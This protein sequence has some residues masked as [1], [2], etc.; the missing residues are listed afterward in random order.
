MNKRIV[1]SG[2]LVLAVLLMPKTSQARYLNTGTGR[3]QTM[4][5][6]A[7]NNEGPLT[8]HKYLYCQNNPVNYAD[9]SGLL[10]VIYTTLGSTVNVYTG[11]TGGMIIEVWTCKQFIDQINAL[12]SG[13]IREID[14][15]GH[16]APTVQGI[17]DDKHPKEGIW[18]QQDGIVRIAGDSTHW[19]EVPL[20][21]VLRGK[22]V[23]GATIT[24]Q[25]CSTAAR[26]QFYPNLPN[27]CQAVSELLPGTFVSGSTFTTH[28]PEIATERGQSHMWFTERTYHTS[29]YV[30][31]AV[32]PTLDIQVNTPTLFIGY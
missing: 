13:T 3:F 5:T 21:D 2:L 17:S 4:D 15:I 27:I 30:S 10:V 1:F 25:G 9:P 23:T 14:F 18:L 24:L 16:G 22:I 7:G 8:L 12:P 6:F 32:P 26:N 20:G 31:I 19:V 28:G 11:R 29:P